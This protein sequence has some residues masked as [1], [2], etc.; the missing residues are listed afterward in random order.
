[1]LF[2]L[3]VSTAMVLASVVFH[4]VG[5]VALGRVLR[6][7][8]SRTYSFGA[9][10]TRGLGLTVAV[11]LGLFVLHGVEIW[12]YALLYHLTGAVEDVREAVYFST[13]TYGAIG[14]GDGPIS[15]DWKLVAGIEGINGVLLIGWSVAFFVTVMDRFSLRRRG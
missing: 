12:A 3:A 5:L 14:Y 15:D 8:R 2:E 7:D 4:G 11:V 10:S 6:L 9:L 1:M 13:I